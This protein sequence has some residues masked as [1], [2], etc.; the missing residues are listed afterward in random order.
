MFHF[1]I[2]LLLA[3]VSMAQ[4][5]SIERYVLPNGL[6]VILHEDHTLP[7]AAVNIW[8]RVGSKDE[9]AGR[10]GFAH[11]FEHLM[12]MGTE[13]VPQG[14]FDQIME[15]GG[16]SNNATTSQDRTNYFESGPAEM[17]PTLL[18]LEADRMEDLGRT[19]T[20][21]KLD[22]QREVVRNER[23]Q[24]YENRPYASGTLELPAMLY[25]PGHPYAHSVIGSHEDLEAASVEDVKDF[26][27]T[28]YI[29]CNAVLVI[30]GDF[31]PVKVRTLVAQLFGTLP[32]G[33]KHAAPPTATTPLLDRIVRRTVEDKVP[34][35]RVTLCFHSPA[36]FA[37][38]DADLD[39]LASILS[40]GA[41]SRMDKALVQEQR[42]AQRVSCFQSS[43]LL[44]SLFYVSA[45]GMPGVSAAKLE[46]ALDAVLL[47]TLESGITAEE[48]QRTVNKHE[49]GFAASMQDLLSRADLLNQYESAFGNP[50]GFTRDLARYR[51]ATQASVGAAARNCLQL[52]QRAVLNVLPK[53]QIS[54]AERTPRDERPAT[55]AANE[56][57]PPEPQVFK[58]GGMEVW[59]L[60]KHQA[61]L[62]S[63]LLSCDYGAADEAPTRA[64]CSALTT[65]L[66]QE[67]AGD[68]NAAAFAG[69][70]DMLGGKVGI[71]AGRLRTGAHLNGLSRNFAPTLEL[72]ADMLLRPKLDAS[73][74][75]RLKAT[76]LAGIEQRAQD[77]DS[78]AALVAARTLAEDRGR[79]S[80]PVAG[81]TVTVQSLTYAMVRENHT[82][83][84]QRLGGARLAVAGDIDR[85]TLEAAL[86]KVFGHLVTPTSAVKRE[87]PPPPFTAT[88]LII[89]D[90]PDAPQT[91]VRFQRDAHALG[92]GDDAALGLANT[93]F[94]GSFTSRLSQNLREKNGYTYGAG[95]RVIQDV[96]EGFFVASSN[97]RTD[98]TGPALREF[99]SE[100]ARLAAKDI[101]ADELS[102]AKAAE[103][104][105]LVKAFE[106][107]GSAAG[108]LTTPLI[109][110]LGTGYLRQSARASAAANANAVNVVASNEIAGT[111]GV[112][113]LVG[114]ASKILPQL[115]GLGLPDPVFADTEGS[116]IK[117]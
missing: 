38:G 9:V 6:T 17:L 60:E 83:L 104:F 98:V 69:A 77:P 14:Q 91:V 47:Q 37:P 52:G 33:R 18:W 99:L 61:P 113:I 108:V 32:A 63:L 95:S 116:P 39:L 16:G 19:M 92:A 74:F 112:L 4:N 29:P 78:V 22:L 3:G 21:E 55:S 102:K 65:A 54:A 100:F 20:Q 82:A 115:Q 94:G 13:R 67:G 56:W 49:A 23:R 110:G 57:T 44:S 51:D 31:D 53:G 84:L 107:V 93:I 75:D 117:R 11:L 59:L 101:N 2:F 64:G 58:V 12:F 1:T 28:H 8:Y 80:D 89:V 72:F 87:S 50:D 85:A 105:E 79:R 30:A 40:D 43:G 42:I 26:F 68:R 76:Q 90:R 106:E 73:E 10:S 45:T 34:A 5:L 48:L 46:A 70:V 111:H 86:T 109:A 25:A 71:A 88:K 114:D 103:R 96:N 66:M 41:A 81:Y 97:V 15:A 27:A 24:S 62:V 36:Q 7:I 35:V